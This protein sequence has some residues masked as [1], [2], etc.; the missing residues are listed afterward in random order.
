MI[1]E[2]RERFPVS[3]IILDTSMKLNLMRS[4]VIFFMK[5]HIPKIDKAKNEGNIKP[6]VNVIRD[7]TEKYENDLLRVN[8]EFVDSLKKYN[9]DFSTKNIQMILTSIEQELKE[10]SELLDNL[11]EFE[12][13]DDE[14]H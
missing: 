13:W 5:E 11:N 3:F 2:V 10:I 14:R 12:G 4:N 9:A 7:F 8:H 1:I 6:I